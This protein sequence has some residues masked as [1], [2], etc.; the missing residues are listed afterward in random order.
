M[1]KDKFESEIDVFNKLYKIDV[2]DRT[3]KKQ[4]GNQS[5]TYLSW[6]HAWA[7]AKKKFDI[8]YEIKEWD[9]KPYLYDENLGYMVMTS[10]TIEGQTY[11][12]WLPVMDYHNQAMKA[13]PYQL[14]FKSGKITVNPAT[15]M[16]INK[17]IMRCLVKNLA[18]FGLG[19]YIYAGEDIPEN[20]DGE[21]VKPP[22]TADQARDLR[23]TFGK[24]SG[25]KL[26]DIFDK[27][28]GYVTWLANESNNAD[29]KNGAN[30]LIDEESGDEKET[31]DRNSATSENKFIEL[32]ER[33]DK[34]AELTGKDRGILNSFIYQ[35]MSKELDE[36]VTEVNDKNFATYNKFLRLLEVKARTKETEKAKK[37]E[38]DARAEQE[39]LFEGNT[40]NPVDWGKK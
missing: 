19:L 6:A 21:F 4:S 18:M 7:E 30:S 10:V 31:E 37:A 23:I 2:S 35:E 16:D 14:E 34:V 1:T 28:V 3:E 25:E 38:Q 24:Y 26:G 20:E 13:E 39:N 11:E 29:I 27:D 8:D 9:G 22:M 33:L 32:G 15:M 5:L 36:E 12:M 40:T 17:T